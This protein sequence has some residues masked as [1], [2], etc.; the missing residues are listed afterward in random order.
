MNKEEKS[1]LLALSLGDGSISLRRNNEQ[2][3]YTACLQIIHSESQIEYLKFKRNLLQKIIGGYEIK[4]SEFKPTTGYR[5]S[6]S[7]RINKAHKYFRLLHRWLYSNDGKKE[8]T[9]K[10]LNRL[11]PQ[12]LAIWY[13]DD[14]CGKKRKDKNGNVTSISC[15]LST[16]CSEQEADAIIKYFS[17][18][19]NIT[20]KKKFH[21]RPALWY[22]DMSVEESKKFEELIKD[23]VIPSMQYKLPSFYFGKSAEPSLTGD[24]I[25]RTAG[26]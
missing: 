19:W 6:K 3:I 23:H 17:E 25:V 13:M 15:H 16:Y 20:W 11:T 9:R 12:G 22:L 7:F 10:I 26:N 18:V 8:Y 1:L 5:A 24:D 14:G 2:K 4:I 21:K